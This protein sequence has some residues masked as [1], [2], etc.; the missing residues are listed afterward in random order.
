PQ[1]LATSVVAALQKLQTE[2]ARRGP[3]KKRTKS[4]QPLGPGPD[5]S[6]LRTAYLNRLIEQTGFLSLSGID[7][8]VASEKDARLQLNAVYTALLTRSSREQSE[9]GK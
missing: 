7:P 1:S 6:A 5:E 3:G 2:R 4:K 8:T 9:L